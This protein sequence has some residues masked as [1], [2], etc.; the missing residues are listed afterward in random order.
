MEFCSPVHVGSTS[1]SVALHELEVA[2]I[3][4]TCSACVGTIENHL[5]KQDGITKVSI[6]LATE[7]G[8]ITYHPGNTTAEAIVEMFDDIGFE[9]KLISDQATVTNTA[10]LS[11]TA[12]QP[13]SKQ[14]ICD[15]QIAISGMTCSACSNTIENH[16]KKQPGVLSISVA[17]ATERAMLKYDAAV[18]GIRELLA[19]FDDIGFEARIVESA[20]ADDSAQRHKEHVR[21]CRNQFLGSAFFA[22]PIVA[23]SMVLCRIPMF[24]SPLAHP[25]I[26]G[27]SLS[28]FLLCILTIPV[29]FGFGLRFY[30][31]AMK[32]LRHRSANMDV[33]VAL[34]TSA[35][36]LYSFL[37][38]V[39]SVCTT[40]ST[41]SAADDMGEDGASDSYMQSSHVGASEETHFFE[42]SALLITFILLGK[43]L[44]VLAKSKTSDALSALVS[45]IPSTAILVTEKEDYKQHTGFNGPQSE[46]RITC[47]SPETPSS[48]GDEE[49]IE[50]DVELSSFL[51]RPEPT[52]N[53][54]VTS[55]SFKSSKHVVQPVTDVRETA[56]TIEAPISIKLV[57]I[58]D[59]LKVYPGANIPADGRI[60]DGKSSVNESMITGESLPV[61]KVPG[62]LVLAGTVNGFGT[63]KIQVTQIGSSTAISQ[64][65][66]L[67]E[68]A[69]TSKA[70]IQQVAD[71]I[72]RF[73]VPAVVS[74]AVLTWIAWFI[75]LELDLISAESILNS[76]DANRFV[77]GFKF[78][79]AVLVIA[80]PCA[81]GLATPTAIMVG[82]GIGARLGI[83]IKGGEAL[84]N[85]HSVST[86]VFDKTG[87]LT[88]GKM[89][90]TSYM[91][92]QSCTSPLNEQDFWTVVA[93]V[94]MGSEHPIAKALYVKA[95]EFGVS[96]QSFSEFQV[97]EGRGV[98]CV[99]QINGVNIDRHIAVG[100]RL[101]M[102]ELGVTIEPKLENQLVNWENQGKTA[103]CV[104]M[105]DQLLGLVAVGDQVKPEA[106][107]AVTAL[108][109]RGIE[110]WMITGDNIRVARHMAQQVNIPIHRVLAET[111]PSHKAEQVSRLQA[112][113]K[114][115]LVAMVGDGVNDSPALAQADVG[116]AIG[117]GTNIAIESADIV[118]MR[119]S[120][121][122]VV[123]AI[124]LSKHT[125]RRIR[126]NYMWAFAYNLLGIPFAAGA[127]FP[128]LQLRLPPAF[129]GLAM[130][131]SSVSVVC[132]SLL[133]K[134][135]KPP[136]EAKEIG[137][138]LKETELQRAIE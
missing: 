100:N 42:T 18:V 63:L 120:L 105:D 19:M 85:A 82:T 128:L 16:F 101:L 27:L 57:Q 76:G 67:I 60:L 8:V 55:S 112:D 138:T 135:Y 47:A 124:D 103:V 70:P 127:F 136:S 137:V 126:Y 33:L 133:L 13:V 31:G 74:L 59:I 119:D 45:L 95:I 97:V 111:L 40:A 96:S 38:I 36:F 104:A 113:S 88:E 86:I 52:S 32:S 2:I 121:W 7:Q 20:G 62:D 106:R 6:S 37:S 118:L 75:I 66:R 48:F 132:S 91:L 107:K 11:L 5:K 53:K 64:I 1:V 122:D 99:M 79:I 89:S 4:M 12:L 87:T 26:P 69:Q 23:I 22:F 3:G 134:L 78:G 50:D 83:L 116:I 34:G 115:A 77:F 123:T 35:S 81:L 44:E 10:S 29:Q 17:L 109:L 43:Y 49:V 108:M 41:A 46:Y 114:G 80:C 61:N 102:S 129:A 56:L 125:F 39:V 14:S 131:L 130:A 72:S 9:A 15:I 51:I 110:V 73:F 90:V 24:M 93:T 84:E 94:E 28:G 58:G 21:K 71:R 25:I 68:R 30:R 65:L 98:R 54:K 92:N 117:S